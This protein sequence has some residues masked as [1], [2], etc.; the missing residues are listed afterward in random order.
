M[1]ATAGRRR[2]MP[3]T[4]RAGYMALL[5]CSGVLTAVWSRDTVAGS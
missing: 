5:T 2:T 1:K 3:R 4:R